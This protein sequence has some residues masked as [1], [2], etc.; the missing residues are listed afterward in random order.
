LEK[1]APKIFAGTVFP[2][3]PFTE[4]WPCNLKNHNEIIDDKPKPE[5][6]TMWKICRA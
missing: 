5:I 4:G 6:E 3:S 1:I 2:H